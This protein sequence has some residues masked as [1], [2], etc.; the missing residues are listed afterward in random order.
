MTDVEER[1]RVDL[2]MAANDFEL[3]LDP[4]D[5]LRAGRRARRNRAARRTVLAGA[6][7]VVLTGLSVVV[8]P[9]MIA[10]ILNRQT[11]EYSTSFTMK[12]EKLSEFEGIS[13]ELV[14]DD[15]GTTVTASGLRG[16]RQVA[17]AE[18]RFEAGQV[19][20]VLLGKRTVVALFPGEI[21]SAQIVTDVPSGWESAWSPAFEVTV[22]VARLARVVPDAAGLDWRWVDEGGTVR[23]ADGS[24]V[25][26][27]RVALGGTDCLVYR[28][29]RAGVLGLSAP[30]FGFSTDLSDLKEADLLQGG[31]G[32]EVD[33]VQTEWQVGL[34]PVGAH[35]VQLTLGATGGAWAAVTL[36]DGAVVVLAKVP[37]EPHQVVTSLTYLTADGVRVHYPR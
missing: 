18:Q 30:G 10:Q 19:A 36:S 9:P 33:S 14:R 13:V 5:V 12:N 27:G 4:Y 8:A 23:H 25:A 11:L 24:V 26:S 16:G 20:R 3:D 29:D 32:T 6:L 17:S 35:D 21:Q 7:L 2:G 1:L 28:D 37:G 31:M 15:Q 22:S 34:L